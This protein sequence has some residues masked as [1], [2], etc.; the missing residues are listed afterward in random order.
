VLVCRILLHLSEIAVRP[1][2]EN[3]RREFVRKSHIGVLLII[4]IVAITASGCTMSSTGGSH[5]ET[6]PPVEQP[7]PTKDELRVGDTVSFSEKTTLTKDVSD[8]DD[9]SYY[10]ATK[11]GNALWGME[12]SG[13]YF[14]VESGSTA[15]VVEIFEVMQGTSY[16]KGKKGWGAP[17][18]VS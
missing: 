9:I 18:S 10:V 14:Y 2:R 17:G 1:R 13:R 8:W 15:K 12:D 16:A 7:A 3:V 4:L 6:H 11:N 5:Q